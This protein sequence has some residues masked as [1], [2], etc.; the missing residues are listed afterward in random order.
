[1]TTRAPSHA[2]TLVPGFFHTWDS[3][4]LGTLKECGRK[5]AFQHILGYQPR[6]LSIHLRFGQLYHAGLERY[7]HAV[8]AGLDHDAATLLMVRWTMENSGAVA[9]DGTWTPWDS[10]DPIKNRYTLIRSLVWQVESNLGSPLQTIILANGK[11]AVE[12][13]FNF[14]A[15]EIGGEPISLA[16]HM[17]KLARQAGTQQVFVVDHKT[18]KGAL[19]DNFY[20]SFSPHNQ[21]SLYTIAGR[22]VLG[23][24]CDG[25]MVNAAQIAVGFTR[26]GQRPI[27]RSEGVLTEWLSEAQYWIGQAR[28]FA[29]AQHWPGNDKSCSSYGGCPF[30]RVCSV[31]PTHRK[32]WLAQDFDKWEWNPLIARGDI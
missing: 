9:D 23:E 31:S 26:F 25:V 12:L 16:G 3:T 2:S 1:M 19:N 10:S 29:L 14:E 4:M 8:A 15:F 11:P 30:A 28:E 32:A 20:R 17:D 13:S 22:V 6:G 7:D 24:K 21:F 18:T 5:F 27:G